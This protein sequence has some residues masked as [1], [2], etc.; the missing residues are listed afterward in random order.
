M[1]SDCAGTQA[2]Q[3]PRSPGRQPTHLENPAMAKT[4]SVVDTDKLTRSITRTPFQKW[5]AG[6]RDMH[7]E[8]LAKYEAAIRSEE[9]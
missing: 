8:T 7:G 3:H 9:S 4:A 5:A 6:E 1:P 2:T